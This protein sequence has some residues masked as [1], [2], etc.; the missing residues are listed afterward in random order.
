[1]GRTLPAHPDATTQASQKETAHPE[2]KRNEDGKV[3]HNGP[4]WDLCS[5]CFDRPFLEGH[6]PG[7]PGA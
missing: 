7:K 5:K 1:M 4:D 3:P 2:R 6:E